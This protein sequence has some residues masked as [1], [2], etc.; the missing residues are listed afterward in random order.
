M[1]LT[2]FNIPQQHS[3]K[4]GVHFKRKLTVFFFLN[5][6]EI[7]GEEEF[8]KSY[9]LMAVCTEHYCMCDPGQVIELF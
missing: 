5:T 7:T 2:F 9:C 3:K 1:S 8:L 4:T 6:A